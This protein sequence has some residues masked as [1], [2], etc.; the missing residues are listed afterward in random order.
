MPPVMNVLA[1]LTIVVVAVAHRGGAHAG[2][3]GA[4]AGFGH[5]DGGQQRAGGEAGEPALA[6]LVVRVVQEV[7]QD[8]LELGAHRATA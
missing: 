1:P 7:R 5:R 3:V 8:H 6:L 4:G 2:E